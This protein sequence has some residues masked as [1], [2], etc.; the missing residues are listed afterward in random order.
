VGQGS[1]PEKGQEIFIFSEAFRPALGVTY[2]IGTG[3]ISWGKA[4]GA[5]S[6]VIKNE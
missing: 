5:S 2:S 4:T 3:V 6:T 1:N